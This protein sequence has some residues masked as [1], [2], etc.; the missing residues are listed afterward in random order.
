MP[1]PASDLDV[2]VAREDELAAVGALT[3][4]GYDADDYLRLPDGSYDHEYAAWLV[5]AAARA[6]DAV[7]LVAT[8][9]DELV[10]TV[11]WCPYGSSSAQL[12]R[13]PRQGEI[14]TLSVA[15]T[16]RRRGVARALVAE[17]L[18]RA[19]AAGLDEI[20]LSSR[21]ELRPAH[22]L[23]ASLG[24]VRRPELD[25]DPVPAVHLWAFS[26]AL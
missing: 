18:R 22:R 24:F 6:G 1:R 7:L 11:T 10:G 20:V 25:W 23:Y 5:D 19:R 21:D 3:V 8:L 15:P 26:L 14:R 13:D 4:A 2:R 9:G 12:A 16:A 17:C